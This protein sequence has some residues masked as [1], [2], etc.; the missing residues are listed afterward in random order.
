MRT[1]HGRSSIRY[2]RPEA[3]VL[4]RFHPDRALNWHD[5]TDAWLHFDLG[6]VLDIGCGRGVLLR[7]LADRASELWGVD[8]D[9][10]RVAQTRRADEIQTRLLKP[11]QPLPFDDES[12]DTVT[13]TEVIEHV[14]DE[15]S[16]L[17]ECARVLVPG[18]KLLLTTPHR[19]LLTF[20]DPGNFKFMAPGLHRFIHR[21][22]LRQPEY[23]EQRFGE[24]R[25]KE[26]GMVADFSVDQEGWHR[27]YRY[28][29][30]ARLTPADLELL[31]HAVYFPAF[32][33]LWAVMLGLRVLTRGRVQDLPWPFSWMYRRLSRVRSGLGDQLVMLFVK[34]R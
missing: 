10:E 32:R 21:T 8:I 26:K 15:R 13:I 31:A 29:E 1:T 33:G 11:G 16:V 14:P 22:V 20:L 30:I 23:Y 6:R 17:A 12:F 4:C 5:Y 27:H 19:G 28:A 24:S 34:R 18:G 3:D 25:R 7:R 2:D 9:E